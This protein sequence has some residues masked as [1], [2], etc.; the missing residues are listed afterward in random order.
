MKNYPK[1]FNERRQKGLAS[2][3]RGGWTMIVLLIVVA[4]IAVLMVIYLPSILEVYAPPKTEGG[5]GQKKPV[6]QHVKEELAPIEQRNQQLEQTIERL[7]EPE[8]HQDE[9][10][11]EYN[12]QQ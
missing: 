8:K 12:R 3:H 4:I 1:F 10:S 9:K 2:T 5:Q 11:E 6:L 7:R